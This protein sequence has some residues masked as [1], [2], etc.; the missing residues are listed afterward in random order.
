M[1]KEAK[2]PA[3]LEIDLSNLIYNLN[4]IREK[5]G[6]APDI[7]GVVKAD[8]Y[9]HGAY[10]ITSALQKNGVKTFGV[11][12]LAEAIELR[13][14]GVKDEIITFGLTPDVFA[15][16]I[17]EYD[18]SPVTCSYQNALAISEEAKKYGKTIQGYVKI[19]TGMGRIGIPHDSPDAVAETGKITT[20][21]N[22]RTKGLFSHFATS[23][24]ADMTYTKEQEKRFSAFLEKLAAK[25]ININYRSFA[26]SGA[27]MQHPNSYY[28]A[29]RPGI[30][31]YGYYPCADSDRTQISI[32]PVMSVKAA[33]VLIKKVAPGNSISYGRRFI[34]ERES[35]IASITLGYADGFPRPYSP[36]AKA[37]V[38]GKIVKIAG[39]ICMDQCMLDVT[40]VPNVK[41]GDEVILMGSDGK[42]TISVD[43]LSGATGTICNE[44]VCAFGQRLPRIYYE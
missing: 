10:E 22:F 16:V 36:N 25:G 38:G 44:I 31:L 12:T 43:D 26:N 17:I 18:L 42:N 7:I 32:K 2:R 3:W 8:G 29:V 6:P 24:D 1:I 28:E 23:D 34:T 27:I 41:V 19:D 30:I 15:D 5:V 37:I 35:L 9:G 20:L 40:D 33:I 11:A 4:S 39:N 14:K 13:E 21:S